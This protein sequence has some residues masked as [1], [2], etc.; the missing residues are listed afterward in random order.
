[1]GVF[2][3][4]LVLPVDVSEISTSHLAPCPSDLDLSC[5]TSGGSYSMA[6]KVYWSPVSLIRAWLQAVVLI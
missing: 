4:V 1:M 3:R 2:A 6:W 5:L